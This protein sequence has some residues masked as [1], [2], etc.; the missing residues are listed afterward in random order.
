MDKTNDFNISVDLVTDEGFAE[1]TV[2]PSLNSMSY[3]LDFLEE[4]LGKL[5]MPMKKVSKLLI[6][7]DE[8]YSN[9]ARYSEAPI[10]KICFAV[11]DGVFVLTI[12][13][14]GN[15]YNPLEAEE[16]DT[17]LSAEERE[18]GG[19]GI[20]MVKNLMDKVEYEHNGELNI[21]RLSMK[22]A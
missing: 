19:L 10:A 1:L 15:P 18:P 8:I 11:E 7:L 5:D 2:S 6:A 22:L 13:D 14:N 9:I 17:T 16:P 12:S 21:L 4:Q 20:M 3:V